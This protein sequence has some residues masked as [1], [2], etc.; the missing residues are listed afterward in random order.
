MPTFRSIDLFAGCGGLSLGLHKAGWD[1]VLAMERDPM[2]FETFYTNLVADGSP[3]RAYSKWPDWLP[4]QPSDIVAALA[5]RTVREG[6]TAL[7]GSIQLVAGGPPCQGFSVGG[8]RNGRDER[9]QLVH[10]QLDVID[11][12][13]PDVA[14][15]ENVEGITRAFRARPGADATEPSVA[16]Q[17]VEALSQL[18]YAAD[19]GVVDARNFAVP[20]ARRRTI[21]IGIRNDLGVAPGAFFDALA[22]SPDEL[23]TILGLPKRTVTAREA[24]DDLSNPGVRVTCPDSVKFESTRYRKATSSYARLMRVGARAGS[25]PDSHRFSEHGERIQALYALAHATQPKGRLRKEFL[26]ANGTKK[27]KKVLIAPDTPVSTITTHPDEF[28]HYAEPRNVTVRE[29]ARLQSFPD[30][31][32]FKGRY[33]INGPRRRFDVARCSQV[34]NAVPPHFAQAIGMAIKQVLNGK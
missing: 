28:I 3:Y 12:V 6:L 27:D 8:A 29:M 18:G 22:E 5:D 24:I 17:V 23:Y 34:G 32:H 20:Q 26:L 2:A 19:Y 4:K 14:L 33:T 7:R 30:N 21:I 10:H 11:M 31:F 1:G 13:R 16:D 9:N 25:I 15:V